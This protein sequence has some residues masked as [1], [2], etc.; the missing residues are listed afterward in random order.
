MYMCERESA[1]VC[2]RESACICAAGVDLVRVVPSKASVIQ[3]LL[4]SEDNVQ[5]SPQVI[6]FKVH[7]LQ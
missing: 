5:T 3:S 1:R 7:D 6:R 2:V 4:S